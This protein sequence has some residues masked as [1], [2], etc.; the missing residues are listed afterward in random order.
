[1]RATR[2]SASDG[3]FPSRR[4]KAMVGAFHFALQPETSDIDTLR[5]SDPNWC[6]RKPPGFKP[7]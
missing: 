4:H 2:S 7:G 5:F 3:K 1:M 6:A